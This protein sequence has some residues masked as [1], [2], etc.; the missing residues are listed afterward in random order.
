MKRI[1][2]ILWAIII[3]LKTI[4][5]HAVVT[6][7]VMPF[8]VT[9]PGITCGNCHTSQKTLS[10]LALYNYLCQNCHQPGDANAGSKPFS[11]GD[12]S[13]VFAD[14]HQLLPA[15]TSKQQTS[16]RW[17]GSIINLYAGA[18]FPILAP[19]TSISRKSYN[20]LTC[21]SCHSM[22]A[23]DGTNRGSL[24]MANDQDQMCMDCHRSRAQAAVLD[25]SHPVNVNYNAAV[26]A[27]PTKYKAV[28]ENA[29]PANP[30]SDLGARLTSAGNV[31]CSTCHGVHFA[32]SRSSTFD[33]ASSAKGKY[34]YLNLSTGDGYLLHTDR[35]GAKVP[36][37]Q[38]DRLN[39]C[40]NCHAGKMNHNAA[41]QDIQCT[42]CHGA[43]M[44]YDPVD[45]TNMFGRNIALIRRYVSIGGVAGR[46]FYRYTGSHREYSNPLGTGICQGCHSVPPPGGKYPAEHSSP[47]AAVCNTCHSHSNPVGSFSA[48]Y[49]LT[50]TKAGSG[51][52]SVTTNKRSITWNGSIGT[53]SYLAG[54]SVNLTATSTGSDVFTSWNGCDSVS[55]DTNNV[56][57][58]TMNSVKS[59]T[60]N[61]SKPPDFTVT[62]GSINVVQGKTGVANITLTSLYDFGSPVT[63]SWGALPSGSS[64]PSVSPTSVIPTSGGA[65]AVFSLTAGTTSG[66]INL[67]ATGG[68]LSKNFS[69][70]VTV[71]PA[72]V[73]P[74]LTISAPSATVTRSADVAYTVSYSNETNISLN[75][76]HIT[77]NKTNTA[78][79]SG[80]SVSTSGNPRTVT[81]S[82]ITGD[83]TLGI[84]IAANTASN[85]SGSAAESAP[86]ATFQ[87][88]NTAPVVT[89]NRPLNNSSLA[90]IRFI[91]G[92]AS[93][94][95]TGVSKVELSV[96]DSDNYCY[97]E[98]GSNISVVTCP[99]WFTVSGTT[100]WSVGNA[101]NF[102]MNLPAAVP[103][104]AF[105]TIKA[106]AYDAAG[107]IS[108]ESVSVFD[109]LDK[110]YKEPTALTMDLSFSSIP[111][112]QTITVGGQLS[113]VCTSGCS[114]VN[115]INRK[116]TITVK[117]GGAAVGSKATDVYTTTEEGHY[118]NIQLGPFTDQ[119]SYT[120]EASFAGA[121]DLQQSPVI[122]KTLTVGKPAGYAIIVEGK[123]DADLPGIPSHTKST[124]RVYKALKERNFSDPNIYWFNQGPVTDPDV[125]DISGQP[126]VLKVKDPSP[127]KQEI[128]DVISGNAPFNAGKS[129]TLADLMK[130]NPAPLYLIMV[131]HGNQGQFYLGDSEWITPAELDS[132]LNAL[133][134]KLNS[135]AL[136]EKKIVVIGACYSGSFIPALSK[137]GRVIVTSAS[138]GEQSY[139]GGVDGQDH[140]QSGEYFLDEFFASLKR[141]SSIHDAFNEAAGKTWLYTRSAFSGT[142]SAQPFAVAS[143]HPMLD[144]NGDG[145]GST[146]LSDA[147]GSEGS[148]SASLYLGMAPDLYTS[149]TTS[150]PDPSDLSQVART[151]YIPAGSTTL[152]S[153]LWAASSS[154]SEVSSAWVELLSPATPLAGDGG[155]IQIT[156]PT[157]RNDM[158]AVNDCSTG[159]DGFTTSASSSK[160]CF[161]YSGFS[162]PIFNTPGR[163]EATYYAINKNTGNPSPSKR[164][165]VY[166]GLLGNGTPV[167]PTLVQPDSSGLVPNPVTYDPNP[168]IIQNYYI[169]PNTRILFQWN[170]G[171]D[172][173]P[174]HAITY[175]LEVCTDSSFTQ[176][177]FV[178]DEI[179]EPFYL[180]GSSAGLQNGTKYY[181]RVW[182]VDAYGARKESSPPFS[183]TTANQN[184]MPGFIQGV[185]TRDDTGAGIKGA[186]VTAGLSS[187]PPTPDNGA[188]AFGL[189]GGS[190]YT[191][192]ATATGYQTRVGI[193]VNLTSGGTLNTTV[194]LTPIAT[195]GSSNNGSF[196]TKPAANLCA[197]NKGTASIV[198][199]TAPWTWTCTYP[200][201]SADGVSVNCSANINRYPLN[202]IYAGN[203]GSG[204]VNGTDK[205]NGQP[206]GINCTSSTCPSVSFDY[207]KVIT[208]T[209]APNSQSIFS[210]WTVNSV[211]NVN[212]TCDVTMN[213]TQNV[214]VK[215]DIKPSFWQPSWVS[216]YPTTLT[217]AFSRAATNSTLMMKAVTIT[218]NV[219]F[220]QINKT[221]D[222]KGGF[223]AAY[224]PNPS[225]YTTI[226]GSLTIKNGTLRVERVVIK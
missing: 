27:K 185:V 19:M 50:I 132:W 72:P 210:G 205:A 95:G 101:L 106:R 91:D 159:H 174:V 222:L 148:V 169:S 144:D 164:T 67:T 168:F 47:S 138:A 66:T 3:V 119:G 212:A 221:V 94:A 133:N 208:L 225:G 220:D 151:I 137:N 23:P 96:A 63:F 13:Q 77:I 46:V 81:L 36:A 160:T 145:I 9:G 172:T 194:P 24:R 203:G 54:T 157:V 115:L 219:V 76:T 126:V 6:K 31:V 158:N 120:I 49:D 122:S 198:S 207:G 175:K 177:C 201:P 127:S 184:A 4:P 38:P 87:V 167:A 68:G 29:N 200:Y 100:A 215:F 59:V 21:E 187:A 33:G 97:A 10:T 35:R 202:I 43:H 51:T 190:E 176:N 130:A 143:Q 216:P 178:K 92:S 45:P 139:R 20:Q 102:N 181:W 7:H 118:S 140:V 183:F 131:D 56:C 116:I 121:T 110:I 28:P 113:R 223:D 214:S 14:Q 224:S 78:S 146:L 73:M 55:G 90:A 53:A 44:E 162:G 17:D 37:G 128:L 26:S 123:L 62:A 134:L 192:N 173:A 141:R 22:H 204:N 34:S 88:D 109:K 199:D 18:Q 196:D 155:S 48:A 82:G 193:K 60:A 70:P 213:G 218:E 103:P 64:S 85:G 154:N 80:L 197:A 211:P 156:R 41:G 74:T 147:S 105:Y 179:I 125:L 12:V 195:C 1:F 182:T 2:V 161:D 142:N 8:T 58:I 217:E 150:S 153:P 136:A 15:G 163:Y 69:I 39:I 61:F 79:N 42:E 166:V 89:I 191:V 152:P 107:N 170:P 206:V 112:G 84:S 30:T 209:E 186:A 135:T 93:D 226:Q 165:V 129:E 11:P 52:G 75:E 32:D 40:M 108:V 99:G 114:L 104:G 71:T 149:G 188:F 189:S 5:V 83:G 117:K 57:T 98:N 124:R 25:G 180:A 16:H 171:S 65:T 111:N 86:S